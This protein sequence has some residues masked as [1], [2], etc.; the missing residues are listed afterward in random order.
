MLSIILS[1]LFASLTIPPQTAAAPQRPSFE[2]A[3]IKPYIA[4]AP[5]TPQFRGFQNQPGGRVNVRGIP[6][7]GIITFAYGVLEFQVSGGPDWVNADL[8]EIV[9]KAEDGA[10]PQRTG[11]RDP[12]TIDPTKLMLQSL[13]DDQFK[14]K[15]HKESKE[16]PTYELVSAKG[17]SKIQLSADQTPPGPPAPG[18]APPPPPAA[19]RGQPGVPPQPGR[20]GMFI[21]GG[22][23]GLTLQG[24][25]VSL[26]NLIFA[27]SQN[28]G[29]I[30]V[31]KTELPP[32]LYD[33]KLQWSPDPAEGAPFPITG[34]RDPAPPSG[35]PRAAEPTGPSL[36]TAI[37]EQLGLR[38]VSS[39]GPIDVYVI[40][41]AQKPAQQ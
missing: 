7:K 1:F 20:G 37:Q 33:F 6:L 21:S 32:G 23:N 11:P 38:L 41:G 40:D 28:L 8:W 39:K 3:S 27:L 34:F 22:L 17:G 18:S 26:T 29:R 2:V 31:D 12:I 14:L 35:A 4:P 15:M 10:I 25:A 5:G 13:L 24:N 19:P 36:V 9:A 16:L 30:V